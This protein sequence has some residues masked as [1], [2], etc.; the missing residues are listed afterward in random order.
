[1]P[2]K[3]KKKK[4]NQPQTNEKEKKRKNG[5]VLR[6]DECEQYIFDEKKEMNIK[7]DWLKLT[8]KSTSL[9]VFWGLTRDEENKKRSICRRDLKNIHMQR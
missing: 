5:I 9:K 6:F 7:F 1:V 8:A 2:K 4:K 3:K